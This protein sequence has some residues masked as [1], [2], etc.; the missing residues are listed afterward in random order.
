MFTFTLHCLVIGL[1]V[2]THIVIVYFLISEYKKK[3]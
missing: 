3:D 2:F 1:A